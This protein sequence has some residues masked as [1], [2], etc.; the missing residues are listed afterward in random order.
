MSVSLVRVPKSAIQALTDLLIPAESADGKS[1]ELVISLD[2]KNLNAR[3]LGAYLSLMDRVYGRMNE[4]GLKS[5]AQKVPQQLV[6]HEIRKGSVQLVVVQQVSRSSDAASIAV[7]WLCL[8]HLSA[9]AQSLSEA[10]KP[11]LIAS[12]DYLNHYREMGERIDGEVRKRLRDDIRHNTTLD[13]LNNTKVSQLATLLG[14]LYVAEREY[15]PACARF[16]RKSVRGITLAVGSSSMA[17]QRYPLRGTP[18]QYED[19]MLPVA[20]AD[21]EA[22]R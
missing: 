5:Y 19:P 6:I 20:D 16:T 4:P 11:R 7:L 21:W 10:A 18:I 12:S 1:V 2:D 13:G 3:E 22:A 9:W 8:K 17:L 14:E 15:L